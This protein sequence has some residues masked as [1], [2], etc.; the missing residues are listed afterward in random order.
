[1]TQPEPTPIDLPSAGGV[2][3]A[4]YRW[5]PDGEPTAVV[6]LTHG[7]GEHVRR[8]DH[9]AAQLTARGWVVYGQ[10]HQALGRGDLDLGRFLDRL[11]SGGYSGP[12]VFELTVPEAVASLE[13][14]RHARPEY[15][16]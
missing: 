11:H 16:T 14:V 7:M 10:D 4:A 6:R 1:M 15:L 8:Y 5:D 2:T 9:L 13:V 12:L 3:V